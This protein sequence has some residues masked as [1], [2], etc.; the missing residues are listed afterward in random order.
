MDELPFEGFELFSFF[1]E[2]ST[3]FFIVRDV[4]LTGEIDPL[5]DKPFKAEEGS[6]H[7]PNGGKTE[8][9][10]QIGGSWH[11]QEVKHL[12]RFQIK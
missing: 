7:T 4:V 10:A 8:L 12:E 11:F 9:T 2:A 5:S 3:I 1:L 6:A